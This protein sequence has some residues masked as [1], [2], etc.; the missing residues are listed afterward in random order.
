MLWALGSRR[1]AAIQR[2]TLAKWTDDRK[3]I[4]QHCFNS[5]TRWWEQKRWTFSAT[6]SFLPLHCSHLSHH[7]TASG[8]DIRHRE[9]IRSDVSVIACLYTGCRRFIVT[10]IRMTTVNTTQSLTVWSASFLL[11]LPCSCQPSLPSWT[12]TLWNH[13]LKSTLSSLDCF[14]WCYFVTVTKK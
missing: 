2:M 5:L 10:V 8:N 6:S 1:M 11:P 13:T 14:W 4:Y 3:I 7:T 9:L 12:L